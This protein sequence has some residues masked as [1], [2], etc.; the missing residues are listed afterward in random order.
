MDWR[1]HLELYWKNMLNISQFFHVLAEHGNDEAI[2]TLIIKSIRTGRG[3]IKPSVN[4]NNFD[5][6]PAMLPFR[7][8]GR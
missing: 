3:L 2:L 1:I 5:H 7:D 6:Y 8:I 4:N